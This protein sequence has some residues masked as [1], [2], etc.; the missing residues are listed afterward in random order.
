MGMKGCNGLKEHLVKKLDNWF[1]PLCGR[2]G[3]G[4]KA[5]L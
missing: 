2:V 4:W 5:R 1:V 3:Y